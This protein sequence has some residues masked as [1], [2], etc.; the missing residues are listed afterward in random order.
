MDYS[1]ALTS[2]GFY[3][4]PQIIQV[5]FNWSS[6]NLYIFNNNLECN[7]RFI[8]LQVKYCID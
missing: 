8:K 5:R 2:I 4:F 3:E 7:S 6:F 1:I